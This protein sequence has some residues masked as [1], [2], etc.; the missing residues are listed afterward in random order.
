MSLDTCVRRYRVSTDAES[1]E[2]SRWAATFG[3]VT[4]R[5][6]RIYANTNTPLVKLN[7]DL[8]MN[9]IK[10]EMDTFPKLPDNDDLK[11]DWENKY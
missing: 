5:G 4:M 2:G 6:Y 3:R 10:A 8:D 9:H 7:S 11:Y 1:T